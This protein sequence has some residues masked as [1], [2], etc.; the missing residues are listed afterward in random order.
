VKIEI[1]NTDPSHPINRYLVQLQENLEHHHSVSIIRSP[2]EITDG[3]LLFLVSSSEF[4]DRAVTERFKHALVLHARDLPKGR[5]WSPHILELLHGADCITVSLLDAAAAIDTGDIYKKVTVDIPRSALWD[6]INDLLFSAEIQLIDFA[7]QNFGNLKKYPQNSNIEATYY[8]KR[9]PK[10]SAIDPN[11][12]ICEQF[13]LIRVC[14]PNRFPAHFYYRGE[15]YKIIL[16]KLS[17]V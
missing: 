6:E 1:L 2:K 8:S 15:T 14:D 9:S 17:N 13:D 5:G 12:P 10:D 3:D 11:K 4:V 7:I 16:E